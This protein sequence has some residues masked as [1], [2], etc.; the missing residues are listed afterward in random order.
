[1]YE[2]VN[3]EEGVNVG[4]V[5]ILLDAKLVIPTVPRLFRVLG[6]IVDNF[7]FGEGVVMWL[8]GAG[9]LKK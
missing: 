7:L 8:V 2:G 9:A 6:L 1:M 5:E 3:A 4:I